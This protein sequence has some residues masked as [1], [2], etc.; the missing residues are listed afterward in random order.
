MRYRLIHRVLLLSLFTIFLFCPIRLLAQE[1]ADLSSSAPAAAPKIDTGDTA[2]MLTS[3]ALVMLMMPGLALFYA[4]MV[5]R[6]NVL[7][8][9][10]HSMA[11]LG[12]IGVEWVVVGYSMAFGTTQHGIVGWDTNLL[13][14]KGVTPDLIHNGTA[15]PE[16][17]FIMFQGMFAIITP[18]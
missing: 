12:I 3:S 10:M 9:M 6:K 11:V 2:W 17:V 18:A 14:L 4:G 15:T 8:T 1:A 13:F 7:G 5:R 16:L